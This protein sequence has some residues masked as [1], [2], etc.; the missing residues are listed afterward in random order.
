MGKIP[1]RLGTRYLLNDLNGRFCG[2]FL[3]LFRKEFFTN[4]LVKLVDS[5]REQTHDIGCCS[6]TNHVDEKEHKVRHF[7]VEH[8]Q[9]RQ[10]AREIGGDKEQVAGFSRNG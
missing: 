2:D 10:G 4:K 3:L 7:A 5:H 6:E 9:Y 8:V 1:I